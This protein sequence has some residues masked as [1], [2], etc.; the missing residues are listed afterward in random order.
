[1]ARR[2]TGIKQLRNQNSNI[3]LVDAGNTL[4]GQE[5]ANRTQGLAMVEAMNLM[6]YDAL[7]LGPLELQ[8]SE[9][10]L[11]AVIAQ[12]KFKVLSA[13]VVV[14]STGQLLAEPY[15]VVKVGEYRVG[16]IGLTGADARNAALS[17]KDPLAT[18]QQYVPQV[19]KEANLVV[20]LSSA[21]LPVNQQ[22]AAQVPGIDAIVSAG[23]QP[24]A[25]DQ[26]QVV[27]PSKTLLVQSGYEGRWLGVLR[28][29]LD[30]KGKLADYTGELWLLNQ[31]FAD[32]PDM[33]ALVNQYKVQLGITPTPTATVALPPSPTR[34]A[35]TT[36]ST[37]TAPV[38]LTATRTSLPSPY[39]AAPSPSPKP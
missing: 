27:S 35:P 15:T 14:Q 38:P 21:G 33:V 26:P 29:L 39:P 34:I 16:L 1:V 9:A 2:A 8:L 12:A 25:L 5:I 3:L 7:A 36:A 30:G 23:G 32:D 24:T 22:I 11:R 28:L 13:N 6:G 19:A 37:R 31:N 17:V 4:T 10:E 20:V 18:A